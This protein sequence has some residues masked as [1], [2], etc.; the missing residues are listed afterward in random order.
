MK[1]KRKLKPGQPGTKKLLEKFGDDLIC[2][3]YRYDSEKKR[4]FKTVELIVDESSW[5]KREKEVPINNLAQ[6][7]VGYEEIDLREKIKAKGAK[8]N[9]L[10]KVWELSYKDVIG[11]DLTDRVV[12]IENTKNV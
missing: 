2:V 11:L 7:R 8:W 10:K 12:N 6:I 5:E 9:K 1:I 3:R 4:R